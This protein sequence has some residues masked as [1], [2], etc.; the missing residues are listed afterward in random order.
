MLSDVLKIDITHVDSKI[1]PINDINII[2][3]ELL[4]SDLTK[5]ENIIE[6]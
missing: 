1:S 2:E 3:T 6:S 5:I 4:L